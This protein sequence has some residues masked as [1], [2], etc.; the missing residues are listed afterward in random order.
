MQSPDTQKKP[1]GKM[2][3]RP[4]GAHKL[5]TLLLYGRFQFL[6]KLDSGAFLLVS[7]AQMGRNLG[8]PSLQVKNWLRWLEDLGY[9]ESLSLSENRRSAQFRLRRPPNI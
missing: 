4:S 1:R 6:R 7:C 3:K 9:I 8:V 2:R 5:L